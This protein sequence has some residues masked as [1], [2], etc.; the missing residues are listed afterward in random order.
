M[1]GI[2]DINWRNRRAG[3]A[4]AAPQAER[5]VA[6]LRDEA[7]PAGRGATLY[8]PADG[9]DTSAAIAA[10]ARDRRGP[11]W[12]A[13]L[14]GA[15]SR[16]LRSETGIAAFRV[17]DAGL[18]ILPPFPLD[19]A[20]LGEGI[21]GRPLLNLLAAQF[22]VGVALIRLGRYA[23]AVYQGQRLLESK[24][25][26]RYVKSK[27]NAGG[28]SRQRRFRRGAREPDPSSVCRGGASFAAA[29]AALC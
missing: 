4:V 2:G 13:A 12:I 14:E 3:Q 18:A 23:V 28:T 22:T 8:V 21:Q 17:G 25:D 27:H 29:V 7:E 6:A 16:A 24:T 11:A 9:G 5:I 15:G 26:T 19:T 10:L 1:D 20:W